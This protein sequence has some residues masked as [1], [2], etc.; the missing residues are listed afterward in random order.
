MKRIIVYRNKDCE[1][2]RKFA[3]A[4]KYLDWLNQVES[5]TETPRCGPLAVGEIAVEVIETGEIFKGVDAVRTIWRHIP[6][7]M[8][9]LPLL[10]IPAIARAVDRES[11]GCSG[12]SCSVP[13]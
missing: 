3:K 11:R 4:N 2:C 1:R 9:L 7:Y 5:S 13:S 8:L 12:T 10:R 6:A